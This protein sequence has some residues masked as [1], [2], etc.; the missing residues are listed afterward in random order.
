LSRSEGA[1]ARR[2]RFSS[3][4]RLSGPAGT[5]GSARQHRAR[6]TIILSFEGVRTAGDARAGPQRGRILRPLDIK[7]IYVIYMI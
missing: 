1:C 6:S 5:S 3:A 4:R 7:A 2:K